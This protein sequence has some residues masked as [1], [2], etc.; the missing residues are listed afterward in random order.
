MSCSNSGGSASDSATLNYDPSLTWN[1]SSCVSGPPPPTPSVSIGWNPGSV[2][3]GQSSVLTWSTSNATYCSFT[4][5][6]PVSPGSGDTNSGWPFQNTSG[7]TYSPL[8]SNETATISCYDGSVGPVTQSAT[9]TVLANAAP[10]GWLDSASCSMVAAGWACDSSNYN[11]ALTIN[12]YRD[13]QAGAGGVLIGT[14]TANASRPDVASSCGGTSLHG[15]N[16]ASAA[17]VGISDGVAHNI[18]AYA[19][20]TPAGTNTL[21]SGNPKSITCGESA[22]ISASPN[23]CTVA[24]G[25]T[26]CSTGV[27]WTINNA[28]SPNVFSSFLNGIISSAATGSNVSE[29]AAITGTTF[30]ARDSSTNLAA[31]TVTGICANGLAY[32]GGTCIACSNGGCTGTGGSPSNPN[33]S[34]VCTDGA[35]NPPI[36][37]VQPTATLS[38]NPLTINAG[39][40]ATLT[41]SSTNASMCGAAGGASWLAYGSP[42]SGS[43][44]VTPASTSNYQTTCLS[45]SGGS[46]NSNIVTIT[47]VQPTATITASPSR[48][49]SGGTSTIAWSSSNVTACTV[50]GPGLSAQSKSGSQVVTVSTQ[51]VYTINCTTTGNPVKATAIVN[52]IPDFQEF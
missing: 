40:S 43:T 7:W 6:G 41:W 20:D 49:H 10:I 18:Y 32:S 19:V 31:V 44:N 25:G 52:I 51:A 37:V 36:C 48:V 35:S 34:L 11:Q 28:A 9:V 2:Y 27:T 5:S 47:V 13:G 42:T 16:G 12:V 14:Y 33:G 29:T 24:Q 45:P 39:Q 22:T 4:I 15:Y 23:P 38:G 17:S 26:T 3:S 50:T 30:T 46:A 1:G 21:L 8:T